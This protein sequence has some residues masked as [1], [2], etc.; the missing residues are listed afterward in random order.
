MDKT[1]EVIDAKINK[2]LKKINDE[3]AYRTEKLE[4]F[5][6]QDDDQINNYYPEPSNKDYMKD[7]SNTN[8]DISEPSIAQSRRLSS[9]S[10]DESY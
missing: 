8:L 5:A 10:L 1:L 7:S 9:R 4:M 3:I 6:D 2:I